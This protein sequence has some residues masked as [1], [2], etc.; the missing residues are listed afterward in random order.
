M[1]LIMTTAEEGAQTQLYCATANAISGQYYQNCEPK[2]TNSDAQDAAA[3]ER[4][5]HETQTWLKDV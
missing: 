2:E 1:D 3:A 4:L 5:W